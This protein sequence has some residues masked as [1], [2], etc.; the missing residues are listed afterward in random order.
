MIEMKKL[1]YILGIT[2]VFLSCGIDDYIK[3]EQVPRDTIRVNFNIATVPLLSQPLDNFRYYTIYYRIYVSNNLLEGTIEEGM[4]STINSNLYSDYSTIHP[5]TN[6]D[7]STST[8]VGTIFTNQKYYALDNQFPENIIIAIDFSEATPV[9]KNERVPTSS[10]IPIQRSS[11][12]YNPA[13]DRLFRNH[14]DLYSAENAARNIDVQTITG[15]SGPMYTYAAMYV[16]ANGVD[17]NYS[18]I[19]SKPTFIGVFRLP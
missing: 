17:N 14:T 12:V 11:A 4:L 1:L 18:S 15:G 2:V 19:F 3:L 7:T 16:V 13:P 6:P 9:I 8:N 5:Y 10:P